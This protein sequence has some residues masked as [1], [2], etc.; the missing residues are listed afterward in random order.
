[1]NRANAELREL[2]KSLNIPFLE[3]GE[4][5]GVC[6]NTVSRKLC[7]EL[8]DSDKEAFMQ[9]ADTIKQAR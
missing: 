5:M 6:E 2:L 3:I 7:T 8:S 1:M 9:A 4:S